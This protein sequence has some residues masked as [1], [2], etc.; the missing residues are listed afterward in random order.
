MPAAPEDEVAA[1]AVPGHRAP[2]ADDGIRLLVAAVGTV[3][4]GG[5][6][7]AEMVRVESGPMILRHGG[8]NLTEVAAGG[9]RICGDLQGDAGCRRAAVVGRG[10]EADDAAGAAALGRATT[11]SVGGGGE[12]AASGAGGAGGQHSGARGG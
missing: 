5:P 4:E 12:C 9:R 2:G 7:V 11:R 10:V 6:D 3:R 8:Q 1:R